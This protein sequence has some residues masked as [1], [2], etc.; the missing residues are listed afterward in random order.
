MAL[1]HAMGDGA[2][3]RYVP[4][5]DIDVIRQEEGPFAQSGGSI[6][7]LVDTEIHRNASVR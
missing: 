2:H 5:T 4:P 6:C 1:P 7:R 3:Q